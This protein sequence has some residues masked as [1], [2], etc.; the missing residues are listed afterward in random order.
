MCADPSPHMQS[1]MLRFYFILLEDMLTVT[2]IHLQ[3]HLDC[4]V[5]IHVLENIL[6]KFFL[7]LLILLFVNCCVMCLVGRYTSVITYNKGVSII[8]QSTNEEKLPFFSA[9][10]A[11]FSDVYFEVKN[12]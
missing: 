9:L 8:C 1:L 3:L 7:V 12:V 10:L 11:I 6:G 4:H 2:Y 5:L